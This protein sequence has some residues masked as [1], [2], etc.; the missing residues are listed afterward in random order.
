MIK[1]PIDWNK[2]IEDNIHTV[3]WKQPP[4]QYY[5]VAYRLFAYTLQFTGK[6]VQKDLEVS[7]PMTQTV[8]EYRVDPNIREKKRAEAQV[9]LK[10]FV[11]DAH[12]FNCYKEVKESVFSFFT[13]FTQMYQTYKRNK[14]RAKECDFIHDNYYY[15]EI[16]TVDLHKYPEYE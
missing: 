8:T 2:A 15:Y 6:R 16:A 5:Y 13:P 9:I 12:R 1:A 14:Q 11:S 3:T 7:V 4:A 10:K